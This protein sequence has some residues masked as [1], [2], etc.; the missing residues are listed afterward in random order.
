[1][2]STGRQRSVDIY[3]IFGVRKFWMG[4]G[5]PISYSKSIFKGT[6]TLALFYNMHVQEC[7]VPLKP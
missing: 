3:G 5:W 4:E 6:D 7:G 2:E 1:M